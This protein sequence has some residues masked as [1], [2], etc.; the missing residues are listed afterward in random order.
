MSDSNFNFTVCIN[1]KDM[2]PWLQ[3]EPC[4]EITPV[5][6]DQTV[7]KVKLLIVAFITALTLIIYNSVYSDL[8]ATH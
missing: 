7:V 4:L 8:I 3:H 5:E 6:I 1:I 2:K